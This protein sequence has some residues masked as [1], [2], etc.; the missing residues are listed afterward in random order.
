MAADFK[1]HVLLRDEKGV[2][3]IPFKRLLLAGVWGGLTYT[4]FNLSLPG[5]SILIAL[6]A[7]ISIVLLTAP[8]GG[9]PLWNRLLYRLR[10]MLLLLA[11]RFPQSPLGRLTQTLELPIDLMRLDGAEV[12]AP[13][14]GEVE[15]NLS[16]WI[17]YAYPAET[18]GLVFV[19]APLKENIVE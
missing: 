14:S 12:F 5:W 7:V 3:G 9:I 4:V 19:D 11:V 10:G 17:T 16:E 18:D 15:V 6:L 2:F 1:S 8:R 13:P